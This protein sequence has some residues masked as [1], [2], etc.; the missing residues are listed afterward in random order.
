MPR[1]AFLFPG[2]NSQRVGMGRALYDAHP[3]I[4]ARYFDRADQIL[5]FPLS[6]LCFEG[7]E[8]ELVKT[9]NQQPA[10]FLVSSAICAVLREKGIKPEAV[11]GHS[12]GEY[13]ALVTAGSLD[14]EG[15]LR[16][17]RRRGELM[18]D[19]GARTGGIMA[20]ILGLPAEEVEGACA[21]A[22]G[23][24]VVEVANYNSPTQTVI[25]GEEPAV[26]AAMEITRAR[27]AQRAI[28]L[29]VSAPFHCSLMASL[30]TAFAPELDRA[31][32]KDAQVP[33]VANVTAGYER[34]AS[35]IRHNLVEQ[36]ASAVRW[37]TSVQRL[38]ADGFD[39]FVE[40][41]PGKVLTGLMRAIDPSAS[42]YRTDDP[43]TLEATVESVSRPSVAETK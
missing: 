42:A 35:E 29:Q 38:A 37:S 43:A 33:V 1:I 15:G 21:E 36:L 24:G 11:T 16:L 2:Q 39:T 6:Q 12:L 23:S 18:A 30:A 41:G 14:F 17:T 26:L 3:A 32:M 8:E 40:V 27:G 34:E 19:V 31:A 20:A 5:G 7:P 9:E 22:S 25:S 4:A 10:I 13:S 28:R